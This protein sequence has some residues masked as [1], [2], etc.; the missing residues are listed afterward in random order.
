MA[1]VVTEFQNCSHMP[2]HLL[3]QTDVPLLSGS[4]K[5]M[6]VSLFAPPPGQGLAGWWSHNSR[7]KDMEVDKGNQ[8]LLSV[9]VLLSGEQPSVLY[10]VHMHRQGGTGGGGGGGDGG[11]E[12]GFDLFEVEYKVT[13]R[14]G[15]VKIQHGD[16]KLSRTYAVGCGGQLF[17]LCFFITGLSPNLP[18]PP[19]G[20]HVVCSMEAYGLAG[21]PVGR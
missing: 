18:L 19:P 16:K 3:L 6:F 12:T 15:W 2:Y 13:R 17:F 14:G 9:S 10:K 5:I 21:S 11:V 20:S 7:V 1:S 8:G 4:Q